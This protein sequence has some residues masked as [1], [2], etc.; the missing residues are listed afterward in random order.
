MLEI[1]IRKCKAIFLKIVQLFYQLRMLLKKYMGNFDLDFGLTGQKGY[2]DVESVF[3][4]GSAF[5][6]E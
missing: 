3:C 5:I 2:G 4:R 6:H 1:G